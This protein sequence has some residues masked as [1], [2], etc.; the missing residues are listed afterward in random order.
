MTVTSHSGSQYHKE[1]SS[2]PWG[3]QAFITKGTSEQ[4]PISAM[5][6]SG[7]G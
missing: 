6:S 2:A 7:E 3:V 1:I 5:N 4:V